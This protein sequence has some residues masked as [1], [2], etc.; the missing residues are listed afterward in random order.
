M[1]FRGINFPHWQDS[2]NEWEWKKWWNFRRSFGMKWQYDHLRLS[3]FLSISF[4]CK[5][6]MRVLFNYYQLR[7]CWAAVWWQLFSIKLFRRWKLFGTKLSCHC[8]AFQNMCSAIGWWLVHS[9]P[10]LSLKVCRDRFQLIRNTK[11]GG[12]VISKADN[13]IRQ[14]WNVL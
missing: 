10:C 4:L 2:L 1:I 5:G 3:S 13:V 6:C 8:F 9:V 12:Q 11:E 14:N 7:L